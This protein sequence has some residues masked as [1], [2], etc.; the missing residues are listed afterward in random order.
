MFS[1]PTM[2]LLSNLYFHIG[3]CI[4]FEL[5]DFCFVKDFFYKCQFEVGSL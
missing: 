4:I 5:K 1:M 2:T 3:I